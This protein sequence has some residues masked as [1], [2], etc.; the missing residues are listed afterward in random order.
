MHSLCAACSWRQSLC[1]GATPWYYIR[2]PRERTLIVELLSITEPKISS[3]GRDDSVS[4]AGHLIVMS[5]YYCRQKS[6][7]SSGDGFR[8]A[9]SLLPDAPAEHET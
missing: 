7:F 1:S 4:E 5:L 6:V 9:P 3:F 2:F 8:L